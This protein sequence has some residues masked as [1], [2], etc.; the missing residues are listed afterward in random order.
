MVKTNY[1]VGILLFDHVDVLDFAGPYEVFNMTTF[2]AEDVKDLMRNESLD[3]PF[4]VHTVSKDGERIKANHGLVIQPE[5]R[6]SNHPRFDVIVVPGGPLKAI[7][8]V[9]TD[10]EIIQWIASQEDKIVTSVCTGAFFV[11]KAGLLKGKKATTNKAAIRLLAK[12][13]P[14]TEAI[15]GAKY[16]D[17]GNVITAAGVS[18]GINM[19][20]H[21]VAK[22]IG[23]DASTR[24]ADTI[25]FV[26]DDEVLF[27]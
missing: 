14:D 6:F 27:N 19:S 21:V 11:A 24:T 2:K 7:E 22:L 5:Y 26:N 25:E 16:V 15:K 20:L 4:T 13:F 1:R 23:K 8:S 10:K 18:S 3:K 17:E 9:T 12:R